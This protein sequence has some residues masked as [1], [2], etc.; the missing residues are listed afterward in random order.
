M[1]L[2]RPVADTHRQRSVGQN[3]A[4][5]PVSRPAM[6]S[7]DAG[8]IRPPAMNRHYCFLRLRRKRPQ[9]KSGTVVFRMSRSWLKW[10]PRS[11]AGCSVSLFTTRLFQAKNLDQKR[12]RVKRADT[13]RLQV[14]R[15]EVAKV[16]GQ[17]DRASPWTAAAATWRYFSSFV[18]LG[19]S[20]S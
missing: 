9:A 5:L 6:T 10:R 16:E 7:G 3:L 13:P 11:A 15:P 2:R 20:D 8:L 17:Y 19:I 14:L 18:I 12:L 4:H 1:A